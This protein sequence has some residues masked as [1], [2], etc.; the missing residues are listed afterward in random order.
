MT[1]HSI[2]GLCAGMKVHVISRKTKAPHCLIARSLSFFASLRMTVLN[3]TK[4]TNS[5]PVLQNI[6][7]N[8]SKKFAILSG[9]YQSSARNAQVL[10]IL[11]KL[12]DVSSSILPVPFDGNAIYTL[13]RRSNEVGSEATRTLCVAVRLNDW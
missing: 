6:L 2:C 5:S 1:S 10:C 13:I 3:Y 7:T 4:C 12:K 9:N 11:P 8:L